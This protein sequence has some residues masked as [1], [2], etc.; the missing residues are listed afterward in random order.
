M[1]DKEAQTTSSSDFSDTD[2]KESSSSSSE[3]ENHPKDLRLSLQKSIMKNMKLPK[4]DKKDLIEKM[5]GNIREDMAKRLR[6]NFKQLQFQ[7]VDPVHME[8]SERVEHPKQANLEPKSKSS[9]MPN[10]SVV[11]EEEREELEDE[12]MQ[13]SRN[14]SK[15]EAK[16]H[17]YASD[18]SPSDIHNKTK[19]RLGKAEE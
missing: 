1:L 6:A 5:K 17:H 8:S 3:D 10:P 18:F 2:S 12:S 13:Y 15:G 11:I 9:S 16:V 14:S 7:P 4:K 19:S